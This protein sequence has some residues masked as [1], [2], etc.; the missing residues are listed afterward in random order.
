[1]SDDADRA[2]E[3]QE[4]VI[5]DA[6]AAVKREPSMPFTGLCYNCD[7]TINRGCFCD[8]DCRDDF[9]RRERIKGNGKR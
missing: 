7:G 4:E 3:R 2:E 6:L 1:M 9:E 8:A 5:A